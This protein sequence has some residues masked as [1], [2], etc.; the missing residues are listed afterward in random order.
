MGCRNA[1]PRAAHRGRLPAWRLLLEID[2]ATVVAD[3]DG[4]TF[5]LK[6]FDFTIDSLAEALADLV[7]LLVEE[8]F[9]S[10]VRLHP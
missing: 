8:L 10:L 1:D 9:L 6:R 4:E 5:S 2:D 7:E 3:V